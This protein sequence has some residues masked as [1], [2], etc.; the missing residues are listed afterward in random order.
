MASTI[1]YALQGDNN[2]RDFYDQ[3]PHVIPTLGNVMDIG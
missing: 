3:I 1:L 2:V